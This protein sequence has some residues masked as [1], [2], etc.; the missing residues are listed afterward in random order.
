[1]VNHRYLVDAIV[2]QRRYRYSGPVWLL[3]LIWKIAPKPDVVFLL[4]APPEL[5]QTRKQEVT[6]EETTRQVQAYR[7][8]IATLPMGKVID[9]AHPREQVATDVE[10]RVLDILAHR[11]GRKFGFE[12]RQR[13]PRGILCPLYR[14]KSSRQI[15]RVNVT[16]THPF[17]ENTPPPALTWTHLIPAAA[18]YE[19]DGV[20]ESFAAALPQG[21]GTHIVRVCRNDASAA[22]RGRR[23]MRESSESIAATSPLTKF[24]PPASNLFGDSPSC[25]ISPMPAGSSRW[26]PRPC[27][28]RACRFIHPRGSPLA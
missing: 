23:H 17:L 20:P 3:K 8:V 12:F 27:R 24:A 13:R 28:R 11:I 15:A 6:L 18:T 25:P 7:S 26:I 14:P 5:I 21:K 4:D 16:A 2:D 10:W 9:A 22:L 1:M 19:C